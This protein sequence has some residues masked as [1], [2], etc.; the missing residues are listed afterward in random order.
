MCTIISIIN[1]KGGVGK[2]TTTGFLGQLLAYLQK[3]TLVIDM[4]PQANISMMLG[5]YVEDSDDVVMGMEP[6]SEPN[7]AEL[8]RYRYRDA[9]KVKSL[10][11]PTAI[12]YLDILPASKRHKNTSLVISANETGNNN[13]ILKK[14]LIPIKDDYDYIIIDNA[15]ANDILTVN[16]MFISD[17]I[18]VPVRLEEF[19][20][21]GLM[22]TIKTILYIK[23]EHD[24]D[25]VKFGGT[26]I[27]QAEA[28]TNSFKESYA[29]YTSELQ[30][31]FLK[32]YIR[33]DIKVSEVEKCFR[34]IL[35][36]CPDTNAVFDYAH[37][38]LEMGILDEVSQQLLA[39]SIGA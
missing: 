17:I 25:T 16:S 12:P 6:P 26:F 2:S 38:L 15:P 1:N 31:K 29:E 24:I 37:L 5:H 35:Q 9:D 8:F 27:T 21:V 18:Y 22:E 10:I 39:Q 14:A 7:I 19:S 33:K 23:S 28:N 11:Y 13:M 30:D 36:Y 3:R 32:T 20:Y 34:P 4:D